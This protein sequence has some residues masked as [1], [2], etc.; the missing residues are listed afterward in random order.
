MGR[1]LSVSA[2]SHLRRRPFSYPAGM[3]AV[4]QRPAPYALTQ[5][6]ADALE[7]RID[8][9]TRRARRSGEAR[10]HRARGLGGGVV[11]P[12]R[13]RVRVA[14]RQ[15]A[16]VL[17]RTAGARACGARGA[18][19]AGR[20]RSPRPRSVRGRCATLARARR[21]RRLRARGRAGGGR[22]VRVCRWGRYGAALGGLHARVAACAGGCVRAPRRRGP[23]DRRGAGRARRRHDR[24]AGARHFAAATGCATGRCRCSIRR[25]PGATRS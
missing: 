7:R 22:R 6:Q 5:A 19:V 4:T 20:R 24:R 14:A 17:S 8:R 12:D 25:P 11:R 21:D 23:D 18:R 3:D 15:R 9:A 13:R 10:A 1:R 2:W 16:V